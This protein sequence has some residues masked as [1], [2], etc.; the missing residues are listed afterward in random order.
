MKLNAD[1]GE[2]EPPARTAALMSLI[3]LANI[4]CG[5]H[6]GTEETMERAVRLA[7]E[8]RVGIGA[9]PGWAADFG[10]GAAKIDTP[11]LGVLLDAQ[12]HALERVAGRLGG[13]LSHVKLHGALY[14]AVERSEELARGYVDLVRARYAGLKIVALAGGRLI[15]LCRERGVEAMPEAFVERGYR[16]DGGLIPRGEPGDLIFE[17][18]IVAERVRSLAENGCLRAVS[19]AVVRIDATTVCVHSDTPNAVRIA[20]AAREVLGPRA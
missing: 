18:G 9:H 14:H 20:R 5:G 4:A 12:I 19:G 7:L 11:E 3:D 17:P 10:R 1:L 16:E 6:A 15:A 8:N 2:N 13:S